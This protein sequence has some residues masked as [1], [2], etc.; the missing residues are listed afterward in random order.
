LKQIYRFNFCLSRL[1]YS[2]VLEKLEKALL[3]SPP[4]QM[5]H[6]QS[7]P[8]TPLPSPSQVQLAIAAVVLSC[9]GALAT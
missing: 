3:A 6:L 9:L 2:Y 8:L 4:V 1:G 5:R 7:A